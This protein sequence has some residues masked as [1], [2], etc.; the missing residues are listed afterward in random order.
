MDSA[1]AA[2]R[3]PPGCPGT[4]SAV[5]LR[6]VL[7]VFDPCGS[8]FFG[9]CVLWVEL[10]QYRRHQTA[11]AKGSADEA[12]VHQNLQPGRWRSG[13]AR[14]GSQRPR[15]GRSLRPSRRE[16]YLHHL[17]GDLPRAPHK[18]RPC[19]GDRLAACLGG[20]IARLSK[21]PAPLERI[22]VAEDETDAQWIRCQDVQPFLDQGFRPGQYLGVRECF[23][24]DHP[25]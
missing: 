15:G 13:A 22:L 10:W 17:A 7:V 21:L 14:G 8:W 18:F 20:G 4:P 3:L 6:T 5:S 1:A 24:P 23:G 25:S 12:Q 2:C 9:P 19:R 11:E 16:P